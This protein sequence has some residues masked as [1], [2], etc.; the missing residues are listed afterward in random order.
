M[1]QCKW[2]IPQAYKII[3][4]YNSFSLNICFVLKITSWIWTPATNF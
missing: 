2:R 4:L 3:L 1:K